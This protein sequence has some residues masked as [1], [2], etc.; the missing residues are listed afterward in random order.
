MSSRTRTLLAIGVCA[1]VV[2]V[3]AI[4]G[5]SL[6]WY[7]R[8]EFDPKNYMPTADALRRMQPSIPGHYTPYGQ[9]L[10]P[11]EIRPAPVQAGE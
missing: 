10:K 3:L 8:D 6:G 2:V 1:V 5:K 7:G 9:P 4:V 11:G